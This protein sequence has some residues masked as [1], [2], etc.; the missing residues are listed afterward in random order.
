MIL[1]QNQV[2]RTLNR[3]KARLDR[4]A[5]LRQYSDE[6]PLRSELFN[7]NQLVRHAKVLAEG[8]EF[9]P[10]PG[11]DRLL[12]R[13]AE[14][15]A[16]LLQANELLTEAAASNQRISPA[17]EWLLDNFYKIEEQIRMAK[18][19]LPKGYSKELPH[20][21]RGQLAGYPRIYDIAKELILHTDGRVDAESLKRFVDAYQTITVLNLGELWAVAIMLRLALIE[22]LR[23]I[24][25]R[26][27]KGRID[28][29]LAGYW[30]DQV[31]LTA[32]TKPK[33]M[34]VVVADL[35]GSDPPMSSS[36]VAEF[37][38]RLEGQ[39]HALA[40]PLIWIEERLSE[41]GKTIA[42][43]VLEDIQQEAADKVSIGNSI[44]SFRFLESM[45][46]RKFVE[47]TSA[48]EKALHMDPVGTFSQMDFATRDRYRHTVEWIARR[49][50]HSE[51]EVA[52]LAVKLAQENVEARGS[53]DRSA[54]V[55]FY[56]IDKGLPEL[57]RAAG[58]GR[59]L[60][61]SLSRTIHQFPLLCYLGAITLVT[62]L[63]TATVQVQAYELGSGGWMR[64]LASIF[65]V[66]CISSPA[67]GLV[68]WLATMLVRPHAL[69]RMDFSLGIPEELRTLVV[70]PSVL[71]SPE[72]VMDLLEGIEVRYLANRDINL[73]FGLLTDLGDAEQEVVP[74]DKHLL[75]M[76]RQGIEAL[77]EKYHYSIFFLFPRQRSWD[78]KE[79]IWRG[80]ERKRGI[81]GELN[82]LLRGGSKNSF[83][84][85]AGD[86][87]ILPRIKYVIT[88]DEDTKMPYDSARRLVENMAHP[89][90]RPRFDEHKQYVAEGYS[91]LH[92][93]LSSGM[94]EADRSRF[95]RLFGGEP[96]IDP[97]TREVSDVYQDIFGEGSFTGKGI[98]DVDAF[99]QS[100]G[101]RFPDNLI[102]SHDL[103]EGSYARA[104]LVSDVQFYEDYPYRYTTDVSRR[105]RWIRG[106]W[107][108]ASWLLMHVPGPGG[109]ILDNPIS[110][111]SRW[112]I[113]DNL[114]RSLVIPAQILLLFLAWLML[115][116]PRFWTAVVVGAVLALP[117]LSCLRTI[118]N[119]SAEL[120]MDQHLHHA[121]RAIVRYL[122]QAGLSL[123][124]LPYEAF[125]SLDAVVRTGGRMLFTH[126]RLLEWT[127]SS[128]SRSSGK[129]DLA[130][131]Y[132]S[133]WI[134]PAVAIVMAS[135]LW[136]WRPDVLYVVWP[137][138]ASWSLAPAVAWWISLP[139]DTPKAKLDEDQT[140]FLRKLSRKTWKFFETFV[141]PISHWLPPDNYQENPRSVVANGTSPTNMGL[142]LLA[143]LAAY[144]FG[145]I[146]A[147]KLIER[148]GSSLQT[149]KVLERS[150]GHFYNW[151]DTLLLLPMP[152]KYISTVDSGN[153]AGHLLTLQQGLFELLDQKILPL[154]AFEGLRDTLYILMDAYGGGGPTEECRKDIVP[155]EVLVQIDRFQAELL[156]PPCTL[157]AAWMLLDQQAKAAKWIIECLGPGTDDPVRFWMQAYETQLRD[158]LDDLVHTAPWLKVPLWAMTH[159]PLVEGLTCGSAEHVVI[160]GELQ[161][162]LLRL[163]SIP[164]LKEVPEMAMKLMPMIDQILGSLQGEDRQDERD[165]FLQLGQMITEASDRAGNRIASLEKLALDCGELAEIR[166]D[167]LFDKSRRLLAIGYNVDDLRRDE[168][169]YDLLASEARLSSFVAIAQGSLKQ[170]HWFAL[171]RMLTI[172]GG[173][174]ALLSWGGTMFE[175]LMPQLIMPTYENTLLNQTYRAIVRRQ[176]EYGEQRGVPWG[177]SESGYNM[178]DVNQIYQYRAFGVPGLGFKRGLIEDLVIAPYASVLALMVEPAEACTNL[179]RM[180][181]EG[182]LGRYGFYEAIDYTPSRLSRDETSATVQ[183]FMAHHQG[184]SFL[185]LAYVLL[186]RP[187]QRRFMANPIFQAAD[188]LLQERVPK[189]APFY[190]H[191][192]EVSASIWRAGMPDWRE[193]LRVIDDP[194]TLRPEVHLLSNGRYS[195][196][197]SSSGGGYSKWKEIAV[198]RWHGDPTR[199]N[200]GMFFYIRDL[201]SGEVWSAGY[202][203]VLKDSETY[204]AIFRGSNAEFRSRVLDID[205]YAEVVVSPEDDVELRGISVTNRSLRRRRIE[206]TSYAEVVLTIPAAD[207]THPSFSNLFVE[208]KIVRERSA[209]LCTRRPRSKDE[210]TP[211]ML[212][213]IAAEKIEVDEVS[214]ETDRLRFIGRGR[215]AAD[216][217]ALTGSSEL[218]DSEGSVLDPIVAIRCVVTIDPG[219]TSRVNFITGVVE[220]RAAAMELIDKYHDVRM[221]DR[222]YNLAWTHNQ[223]IMQQ[224]NIAEA[225]IQLYERLVSAIIYPSPTWRASPSVLLSNHSGQSGLWAYGISGDI[226][227]VLLRIKDRSYI[228]LAH[229]LL[230]AH[231]YWHMMGLA[232]DLVIWNEEFS[233]Y[234]QELQDEIMGLISIST[235]TCTRER[236][237]GVFVIHA[238]QISEEAGVLLQAAA[239]AIFT[240]DRGTFEEQ[241]ERE[242]RLFAAI[243]LLKPEKAVR[244]EN[245]KGTESLGRD[246][247]FFNGLGGFTKDG[248]EYVIRIAPG[249]ATPAPWSNVIANPNFGTVISESG[250]AYTWG[251][252]SQ[253]FRLTPWYND[254]VSDTSGEAL[255]IRDEE[256]GAF[257]SPTALP[258]RGKTPYTCRHGF[259]YSV[260]EH[261]ESGILSELWVYVAIDAPMKFCRL[262]VKN[263]S[264]VSRRLSVTSYIE[265]VL[266]EMHSKTG[267]HIIT[268]IDPR[269]GALFARNPYNT[270]FPGR[271]VFLDVNEEVGSFS[272]DRTEFLGRN[273]QI[274]RPAALARERLSN[275]VG[276]AMDPCAAMQ[277][278]IDLA[279]GQEREIVFTFGIGRDTNDARSLILR[280][281][282]S[283]PARSALEAVWS[284]WNRTLG[285]VHVETPDKA[286]NVLT[287]GWL[288]YQTL[289]CRIWARSGYYQSSGAFGFRDQLQDVMALIYTEPRLAREHLLRCAA[290]QF[291]EGD[292]L[293]WW[294]SPSG[295]GVRTHS[296]DDR[297]WLPLAA[298]R[299]VTTTGDTGVLDERIK[300]IEGRLLKPDEEAYYD[301]P[302]RSE[303]SG[304]LYEHCVRAIRNGLSFGQH[305]LPLMGSGDWND[306]M[307]RVGY[308]GRGESIWLAFFL[309]H[310]LMKFSEIAL[311]YGDAAFANQCSSE[312]SHLR[313]KIKEFGW[314]GHWYLRAYFDNTE[315][316]GSAANA[317]CQIDSISQSWSV[318]SGAGD[319]ER[320]KAAMEEVDRLLVNRDASLIQLLGPPFD[321]SDSDPGYIKGYIPGV[322]ENGGQYTHAAIWVIMAFAALGDS[323]RAWEL[324]SIINPVNHG[325][326][327]EEVAIYMVEPYVVAADVYALPPH[328]G[329]G[330]W[331]WYTGAA[332]WMYSLIVESL[333]GLRLEVDRL[334]FAPCLPDDWKS[335][336][337]HYRY[338]ET[339][340]H[341][342]VMRAGAAQSVTVDGLVQSDGSIRLVDDQ[343]EHFVEIKTG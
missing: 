137:L 256:S 156:S 59:S 277:V 79:E 104:A 112:K 334:R 142:S 129:S 269:T 192:S 305:G 67:V 223:M 87:S 322:R 14:N 309:Y 133:M 250:G 328:T 70:V 114:R 145:Y 2:H 179:Q 191:A 217:V 171:G 28:H 71:T 165:W 51:E 16:I 135:Y 7:T 213:L 134:A 175:Y 56:L 311:L 310:V 337:L 24:S 338:R 93:R 307:N 152:P 300:F 187:M 157:S 121:G 123:T 263:E 317:E 163:D 50:L 82:S 166:Y 343:R 266:G 97:Y 10:M 57:E 260:F 248:R 292:V 80:Y 92:P 237:G 76:A 17:S 21:Q 128:S 25:L 1:S 254:P 239:R 185:S 186:D 106:D 281:R 119:K 85:I 42:Q 49:S 164:S 252:N 144:D 177:I 241:L 61:E 91:I 18:R 117:V 162:K 169:C 124:F 273:G 72:K 125:F 63:I 26:I 189:A 182:Y 103:L 333:L 244:V 37:A 219:E 232:V 83:S 221:A 274:A 130:G 153:L 40:V 210:R 159:S 184:M 259:G 34:I 272:G 236:S 301:L 270:N 312:S 304:T 243:P 8:H 88:V 84:L 54:H 249:Q 81:L 31:I 160:L 339:F 294:H 188:L 100:L 90:N 201:D 32:E 38:R 136:F 23:R 293:H 226:P 64:V 155:P 261:K 208:T 15:E 246:L 36:F 53:E 3:L 335:Y 62:A 306:S 116:Q 99:S 215:T 178:T 107:Q 202:Q 299:Y 75:L 264:G 203:P 207:A 140:I 181:A 211:W 35:A 289:A 39:S 110:A 330:G 143:N 321:K 314:D 30:A 78:P 195:V 216:P 209:I 279:D 287:N 139:L 58:M 174:L 4:N 298:H 60:M 196:M 33:S 13:L 65:L 318:L 113:L 158:H 262:L 282:G 220:T 340:Y 278:E 27:A 267:M 332:G 44:G 291:Q 108:I 319:P 96:G 255:Y 98:Y 131:I 296:S 257:W 222:V 265:L 327:P 280:F 172:A 101:G 86:V 29:N 6:L 122:A 251:E 118:L 102:L 22:N 283:G 69:P 247:I 127:S 240:D 19:H 313:R 48:V 74:E 297:L 229:Q 285:A 303:E 5:F 199:D 77:N 89:L 205:T 324:L 336:R 11:K 200:D 316:L 43:M 342:T 105:H 204:Q 214:Y 212:H 120:P 290:H 253:Q 275:R 228:D 132:Q 151:Y 323:T 218:S 238:D 341:I 161:A 315:T 115:L 329:R 168:S 235:D 194:N 111:L 230:R 320:S 138:L 206:L 284:Y 233:G 224:L 325:S 242:S 286:I 295:R 167:L 183:S 173:E 308:L 45:D 326:T 52:L 268:E 41:K 227:I 47:G 193:S 12:P 146:S 276:A 231:A 149:M 180:A 148:T 154:Q 126:K 9:D 147:G 258:A 245:Y 46:W 225:H 197:V 198:T 271:I 20:M 55:G 141:G 150:Q 302:A 176:I 94:P 95:V 190:P 234:R 68:N 331:T 66:I 109:L 170:E 288:L 73:H